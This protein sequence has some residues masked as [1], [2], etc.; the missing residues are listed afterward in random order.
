MKDIININRLGLYSTG[1]MTILAVVTFA[2]AI[3]TP[4]VSG[5]FCTGSCVTYPYTDIIS[6]F[7]KDYIWMYFAIL[8]ILFYTVSIVCVH[9]SS[10]NEKKIYSY[11]GL[12]FSAIS[13][14]IL[15]TDYFIQVTV[16]Q[17]SLIK[18]ETDGIALLTQYNP[19]GIFISMEELGYLMMSIAFIFLAQVFSGP[20]KR[21]KVLKWVYSISFIVMI[22]TFLWFSFKYGIKR[23]YR[24]EVAAITINFT[25]L[26]VSGILLSILFRKEMRTGLNLRLT[27]QNDIII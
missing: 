24:F 11:L 13:A 3:C 5:P 2:V 17:P 4:P 25:T 10:I 27:L 26:I 22:I 19:H 20:A 23:E 9:L 1:L 21:G 6:R 7:P 18:G 8:M 14:V 15:I 16:V 12:T